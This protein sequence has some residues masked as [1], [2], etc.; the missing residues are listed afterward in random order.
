MKSDQNRL[1]G[2]IVSAA[3]RRQ[4]HRLQQAVGY[5]YPTIW[6]RL[7]VPVRILRKHALLVGLRQASSDGIGM[8]GTSFGGG[9]RQIQFT[10]RTFI[11]IGTSKGGVGRRFTVGFNDTFS[12]CTAQVVFAKEAGADVVMGRNLYTGK[13]M[14][15]RSS[16]VSG[17][18]CSVRDG[19]VFAGP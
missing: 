18:S 11:L 3:A 8:S 6:W 4:G 7:G 13:S 17:V 10:G 9:P 14:E 1:R 15:I 12:T 2:F 16:T 19:N 5:Q